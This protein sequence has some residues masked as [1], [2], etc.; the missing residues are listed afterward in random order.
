MEFFRV[1]SPGEAKDIIAKV[2]KNDSGTEELPVAEAVGRKTSENIYSKEVVPCFDKSTVDGFAV[3][4]QD[5]FGA[6]ESLPACLNVVGQVEMGTSYSEEIKVGESVKVAT[7]GMLPPGADAVVMVEQTEML[8]DTTVAINKAV[9]PGENVISRGEDIAEGDLVI[10]VGHVLRP[11][12]LGLL[13]G[14]GHHKIKV[15]E[16]MPVGIISTGDEVVPP[17]QQVKPGQVKDI[18]T[19]TLMG[20][21][22]AAGGEAHSYGIIA[23]DYSELKKA[24][25]LSVANNHLTLI[26]GGSSVGTRDLTWRVLEEISAEQSGILFHGVSIKPGKPIL[27]AQCGGGKLVFGLPGH[28]ASAMIGFQLLVEPLIRKGGYSEDYFPVER[29]VNAKL[30]KALASTPGRKD[31]VRVK[32]ELDSS[33]QWL[34]HPVLGKSGLISPMV[35]A[36]GMCV[37]PLMAEGIDVG[38][39]VVVTLF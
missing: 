4:S 10:D 34:A 16:K 14:V 13:A 36:D 21:V 11:Q 17:E 38:T 9:A 33:G 19:Y 35:R 24:V 12:D 8:D 3:K 32:L 1:V 23:D 5:T 26:S 20:S 30:T 28:P 22:M 29:T 37:I 39:E 7:G 31:Y 18:N 15:Q 6:S 25:E 2:W 27:A